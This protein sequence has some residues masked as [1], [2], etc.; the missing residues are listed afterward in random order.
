MARRDSE[1]AALA[2]NPVAETD[3]TRI[4]GTARGGLVNL[5]GAAV[6]GTGGLAITWLVAVV[7]SPEQ[8]GAFFAATSVFLVAAA[9]SRLG[10]PTGL[11]YWVARLRQTGRRPRSGQC[12]AAP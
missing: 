12:C 10:T 7:L 1:L 2:E 8:A 4:R 6:A 9:V 11:V 3:T 5:V